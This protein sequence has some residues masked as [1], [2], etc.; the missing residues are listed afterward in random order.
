MIIATL[1]LLWLILFLI[2]RPQLFLQVLQHMLL[3]QTQMLDHLR[4]T[5]FILARALE[6]QT[7][8]GGP[9]RRGQFF[10]NCIEAL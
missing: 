2:Y 10:V 3:G 7:G 1:C 4:N 5:P 6:E 9:N 8:V